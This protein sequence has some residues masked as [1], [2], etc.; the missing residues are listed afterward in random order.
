M[1]SEDTGEYYYWDTENN[2][3]SWAAPPN[4]EID[5]EVIRAPEASNNMFYYWNLR[6]NETSWEIMPSGFFLQAPPTSGYI[7]SSAASIP[8][9]LPQPLSPVTSS[10]RI[11]GY[12]KPPGVWIFNTYVSATHA[13]DPH[14]TA[15]MEPRPTRYNPQSIPGEAGASGG[16][17]VAVETNKGERY[18]WDARLVGAPV[19]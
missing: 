8:Q 4:I 13:M 1:K 3:V 2:Q 19:F 17:W 10:L 12:I 5:W 11:K 9:R 16:V 14:H 6:S 7:W 15:R 18:F